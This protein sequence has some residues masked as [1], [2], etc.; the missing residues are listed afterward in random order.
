MHAYS[1]RTSN[2]VLPQRQT[3]LLM[4]CLAVMLPA[5]M[6]LALL[7]GSSLAISGLSAVSWSAPAEAQTRGSFSRG[8]SQ[9]PRGG[10]YP[11]PGR[12]HG[13]RRGGGGAGLAIGIG[14][15]L[16]LNELAAEE[17]RR[18]DRR[19]RRDRRIVCEGGTADGGA[20]YCRSGLKARRIARN[21]YSCRGRVATPRPEPDGPRMC[22]SG[23]SSHAR[24]EC[25]DG[26]QR[27]RVKR[28]YV[29]VKI[30][31]PVV[32]VPLPPDPT[33]T[34][35]PGRG[36]GS[37]PPLPPTRQ[38][39][40]PPAI[41]PIAAGQAIP[42]FVPDEVLITIASTAPTTLEDAIAQTYSL[43][44]LERL[45]L[46]LIGQRLV[47]LR[48]PATNNVPAIV[49]ALQGDARVSEA[50]ANYLYSAQQDAGGLLN[51]SL[52]YALLKVKAPRALTLANG[53][54]VRVA[55]ID[56]GVDAKHPDLSGA[57]SQSFDAIGDTT[58][59]QADDHG[60]SVAGIIG[61][62]GLVKGISPE[63]EILGVRAFTAGVSGGPRLATSFI[64]LRGMDWAI[65][66][67][68]RILNLSFAGPRDPLLAKAVTSAARKK[69]IMVAAAGNG[70]SKAAP[71]Y[72]AAYDE[73][74]A[75]TATD[76]ADKLYE[77]ANQ[78]TYIAVAS[79]GVDIL[80][81]TANG[82]H[83]IQSGTSFAA[84]HVS[85]VLALMLERRP[86]LTSAEARDILAVTARDL[87]PPGRDTQFGAGEIDAYEALVKANRAQQEI[88]P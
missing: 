57:V 37:V 58:T 67:G 8:F 68:A 4:R 10:D 51:N 41:P 54:G 31:R 9:R 42:E 38:A 86:D 40:R 60:T 62:R 50:Q 82:A 66:N 69:A 84:A 85:G 52:Q 22:G 7:L 80:A 43:T 19:G 45:P 17:D 49:V 63:A 15:A 1:G 74:I 88:S 27:Q 28:R 65:T 16:I 76:T 48:I 14:G 32:P 18:R 56:T 29:C 83:S 53:K 70:G 30:A 11:S 78:G 55:V 21:A 12:G 23:R 59:T 25:P 81:P 26:S 46:N 35:E 61:G 3:P 5:V 71:A 20:C 79:P 44:I 87:G 64:I 73:V 13:G 47:R 6:T 33:Q 75:V 36:P 39:A 72:P 77:K 34:V 2:C 24:C